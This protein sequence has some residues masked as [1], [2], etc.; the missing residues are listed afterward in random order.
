MVG[1]Q[2]LKEWLSI[3]MKKNGGEKNRNSKS[4]T[5]K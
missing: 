2:G 3:E 4:E 5:V 1:K